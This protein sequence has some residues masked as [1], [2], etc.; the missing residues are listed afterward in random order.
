MTF[1]LKETELT[2]GKGT[3][4]TDNIECEIVDKYTLNYIVF[5]GKFCIGYNSLVHAFFNAGITRRI[6]I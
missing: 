5:G 4:K 2:R 1:G 3:C 6:P